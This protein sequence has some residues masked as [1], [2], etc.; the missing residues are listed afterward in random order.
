MAKDKSGHGSEKGSRRFKAGG[1]IIDYAHLPKWGSMG[2]SVG[3]TGHAY[4][5]REDAVR[6]AKAYP[7]G[8]KK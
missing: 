3:S 4:K 1:H 8:R 7:K 5:N 2:Y 6:Y